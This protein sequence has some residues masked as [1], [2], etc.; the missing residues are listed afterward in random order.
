MIILPTQ[1]RKKERSSREK[2]RMILIFALVAA[3]LTACGGA[4]VETTAP[5]TETP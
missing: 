2:L 4:P 5:V 3:M 1:N